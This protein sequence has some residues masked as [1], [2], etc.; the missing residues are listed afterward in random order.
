MLAHINI[1]LDFDGNHTFEWKPSNDPSAVDI[2]KSTL[3]R[4]TAEREAFNVTFLRWRRV[5]EEIEE[6][7]HRAE[8]VRTRREP[9]LAVVSSTAGRQKR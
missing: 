9:A 7:L 1:G 8:T 4:W 5:M 6:T 3:D 2:P